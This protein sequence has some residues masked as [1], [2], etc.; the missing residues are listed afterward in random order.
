[1]LFS[2]PLRGLLRVGLALPNAKAL[3]YFQFVRF[4]DESV[5]TF[6]NKA[7]F[8][9]NKLMPS[10]LLS[11]VLLSC[12]LTTSS[13]ASGQPSTSERW[14]TY[15]NARFDYSISYPSLLVPQ[16]E[17][18]NSDGQVFLSHDK[19]EL[20]VWGSNN[21]LNQSLADV[22]QQAISDVEQ[23]RGS[24]SYKV[25]HSDFFVVS[26]TRN[27]KIV[28]QKTLLRGDVFKTFTFS[29][30]A[31]SKA[32]YDSITTRIANSFKG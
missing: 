12:L 27:K 17:S 13:A 1:M 19:A 11:V 20:R 16:G 14:N 4:A 18:M 30:P 28:Y 2:R 6:Q 25:L 31:S 7:T 8:R 21:A 24:V 5:A 22:Y 3:G 9:E 15:A 10:N 23:D 32:V 26:G 29:Y